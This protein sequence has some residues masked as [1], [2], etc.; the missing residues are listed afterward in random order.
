[1]VQRRLSTD[2]A[3]IFKEI[4]DLLDASHADSRSVARVFGPARV[5]IRIR[6]TA[7]GGITLAGVT[8]ADVKS[9]EE[10]ASYFIRGSSSRATTS[11]NMNRQSS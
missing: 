5:P 10:M 11:T 3:G 9:K 8:E 1:M 6:G 4:Y 7:H 2:P